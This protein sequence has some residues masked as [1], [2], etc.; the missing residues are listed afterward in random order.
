MMNKFPTEIPIYIFKKGRVGEREQH[1]YPVKPVVIQAMSPR[2]TSL[3]KGS[4]FLET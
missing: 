1:T 3:A 4:S 2:S